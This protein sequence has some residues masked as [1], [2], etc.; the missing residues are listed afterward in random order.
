MILSKRIREFKKNLLKKEN[1]ISFFIILILFLFDRISKLKIINE[2]DA[3]PKYVNDFINFDLIWNTG[4]GFG[5]LSSNSNLFYNS[6]TTVIGLVIL[7]LLIFAINSNRFEK[8][9]ITVIISGALGN[10]YDR[11]Y[12]KAV[13]DFIDLHYKSFHWFTF[14]IADMFITI[15]LIALIIYG[16]LKQNNEKI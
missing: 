16:S 9:I 7:Y 4:I 13:P 2:I 6:V 11:L 14:N 3:G 10:F 8:F 12:F 1:I 15:G 5:L